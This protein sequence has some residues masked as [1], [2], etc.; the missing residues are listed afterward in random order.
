MKA[1]ETKGTAAYTAI[2]KNL[3]GLKGDN[4]GIIQGIVSNL[5]ALQAREDHAVTVKGPAATSEQL[6]VA[7][8]S[9]SAA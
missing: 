7:G 9:G 5:T 2:I 8:L 3:M 1:E 4:T 6:P